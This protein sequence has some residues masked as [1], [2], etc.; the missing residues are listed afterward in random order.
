MRGLWPALSASPEFNLVPQLVRLRQPR[1][2]ARMST[3]L[4]HT[5]LYEMVWNKPTTVN[6]NL[7]AALLPAALPVPEI[8]GNIV[9][10]YSLLYPLKE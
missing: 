6:E 7:S 1:K 10:V 2:G 9:F 3:P 8:P 4:D 5:S